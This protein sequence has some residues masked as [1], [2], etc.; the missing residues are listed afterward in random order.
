L[1]VSKQERGLWFLLAIIGF[2]ALL[3]LSIRLARQKIP[4]DCSVLSSILKDKQAY[5]AKADLD[6]YG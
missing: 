6:L 4:K 3:P 1:I 2:L 5:L